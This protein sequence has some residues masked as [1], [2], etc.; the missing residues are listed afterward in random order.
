[1]LKDPKLFLVFRTISSLLAPMPGCR[2]KIS[3]ALQRTM[4]LTSHER[5][6]FCRR[7]EFAAV[8]SER[9]YRILMRVERQIEWQSSGQ[10]QAMAE[11][12]CRVVIR[13]RPAF[14]I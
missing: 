9:E 11:A 13:V 2:T 5:H 1:M 4:A 8:M 10:R 12:A 6:R 7:K 14:M 3:A